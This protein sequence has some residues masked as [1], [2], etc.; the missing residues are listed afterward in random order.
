MSDKKEQ[1]FEIYKEV[2]KT[3]NLIAVA[4]A[5]RLFF[6]DNPSWQGMMLG[7]AVVSIFLGL[8]VF[9]MKKGQS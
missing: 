6:G 3:L 2:G 8:A 5:G 7:A 9:V 1:R 4:A